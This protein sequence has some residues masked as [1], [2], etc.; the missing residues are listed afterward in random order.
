MDAISSPPPDKLYYAAIK[1]LKSKQKDISW[2]IK[3]SNGN[4]LTDKENILE[5]WA[6]FY[7]ELYQDNSVATNVDD[8][9]E[10]EIPTILRH[11]VEHAIRKLKIGKS[12]E[13]DNIYSEY[14]NVGGEP[15]IK[16]LLHLFNQILVTGI[17]QF[18][19]AL[20]VMLYKKN[21]RLERGNYRP[22]SLFINGKPIKQ[23]NE[24]VYLGH[25]LSAT[26]DGTAAVKH[27]IGLGWAAFE[28]NKVLLTSKRDPYRIEASVY[29][30]YV[31]PVGLFGLE[32]VN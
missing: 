26:N 29:K 2:G 24:F 13:L 10:D 20:I 14:I 4:I 16:A 15:L 25:K 6:E 21:S 18:K 7:E 17:I 31:L 9:L 30:T 12:P 23:V 11:E 32:C 8:T 3:D 22:I 19:E 28:K 5:R 27:R 1:R